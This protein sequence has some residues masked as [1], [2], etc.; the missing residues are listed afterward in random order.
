MDF[1]FWGVWKS[2]AELFDDL[3]FWLVFVL[4]DFYEC[5]NVHEKIMLFL[6][7]FMSF[8]CL[9]QKREERKVNSICGMT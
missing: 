1:E 6:V 2:L 5:L 3:G 9:I 4:L 8:G 7:M